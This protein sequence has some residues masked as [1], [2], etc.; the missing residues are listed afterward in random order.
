MG[1]RRE[2]LDSLARKVKRQNKK[3]RDRKTLIERDR[4][5]EGNERG[6]PMEKARE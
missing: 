4:D 2:K 5:L 1:G 3:S 6:H